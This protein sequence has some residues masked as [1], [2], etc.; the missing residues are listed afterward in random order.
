MTLDQLNKNK[1]LLG[2]LSIYTQVH[3]IPGL[4][5][6][7]WAQY[8]VWVSF[9]SHLV[10]LSVNKWYGSEV[11]VWA[12]SHPTRCYHRRRDATS[13]IPNSSLV[14]YLH[15]V[16]PPLQLLYLSKSFDQI[17]GSGDFPRAF[18]APPEVFPVS[19]I[20]GFW[21]NIK[22]RGC[23]YTKDL[24]LSGIVI[25]CARLVKM[26]PKI[27]RLDLICILTPFPPKK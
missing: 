1:T 10:L 3:F 7:L 5:T 4:D 26:I 8:C 12:V 14:L 27:I 20:H 22:D 16:A 21:N 15:T 11:F 2:L 23:K 9:L 6:H 17:K 18:K 13:L 19:S 25:T 24:F